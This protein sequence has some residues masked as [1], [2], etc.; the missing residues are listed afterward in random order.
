MQS[1]KPRFVRE[2]HCTA[3]FSLPFLRVLWH[4]LHVP[5]AVIE[6]LLRNVCRGPSSGLNGLQTNIPINASGH[7]QTKEARLSY[8]KAGAQRHSKYLVWHCKLVAAEIRNQECWTSQLP[9]LAFLPAGAKPQE[10]FIPA[11]IRLV[12]IGSVDNSKAC[13][14]E[15]GVHFGQPGSISVMSYAFFKKMNY[16]TFQM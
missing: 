4:C 16:D 2:S 13:H 5:A 1:V 15:A 10:V 7:P 9:P 12:V 3:L 6:A 11:V 8:E 14:T